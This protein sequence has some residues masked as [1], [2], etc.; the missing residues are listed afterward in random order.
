METRTLKWL[1]IDSCGAEA[2]LAV[3]EDALALA[4]ATVPGR[5]FSAAWPQTL[6]MLLQQAGWELSALDVMGV[7]AGPGSFTGVRV[8]VAVAKGLSEAAGIPLV[9]LSRLEVLERLS[10]H[11]A[12]AVL[13][14]GRDEFY[15]R[16]ERGEH[17]LSREAMIAAAQQGDVITADQRVMDALQGAGRAEQVTMGAASA[18]P[19]LLERVAAGEFSNL[20]GVDANY[21]RSESGLYAK[22]PRHAA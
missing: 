15:V 20:A 17:L 4:A 2:S 9:A 10:S 19:L 16:D 21:V 18:L 14:A 1:L 8:G 22:G 5:S 11:P 7:V 3:G 12:L 13:D 6:R